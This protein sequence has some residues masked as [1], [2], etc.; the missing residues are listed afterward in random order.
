MWS[1]SST[2]PIV[3]SG[4]DRVHGTEA[5]GSGRETGSGWHPDAVITAVEARAASADR[6]VGLSFVMALFA[7]CTIA[8]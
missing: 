7:L 2:D 6:D 3:V 1:G 4:S 5:R 8:N